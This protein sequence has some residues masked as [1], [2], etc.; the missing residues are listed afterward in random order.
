MNLHHETFILHMIAHGDRKL[1]YNAAYPE[2]KNEQAAYNNS[3]RL[4][5]K[6]EIKERIEKGILQNQEQN[7]QL[8]KEEFGKDLVNMVEKRQQLAA[9]IRGKVQIIRQVREQGATRFIWD[10]PTMLQILKAIKLD[11]EMEQEM[12]RYM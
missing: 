9:I 4:L 2:T 8:L 11:N 7:A 3:C 6:P 12:L 5:A 1:A 10:G